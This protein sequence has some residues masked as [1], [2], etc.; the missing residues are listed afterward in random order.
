MSKN[1]IV[2]RTIKPLMKKENTSVIFKPVVEY[3]RF[4]DHNY[5]FYY[6]HNDEVKVTMTESFQSKNNSEF[7][8]GDFDEAVPESERI[9][10]LMAAASGLTTGAI[11]AVY[12]K[13]VS[14]LS[15]KIKIDSKE[16]EKIIVLCA[17][18]AGYSKKDYKGAVN[19]ILSSAVSRT[20]LSEHPSLLGLICSLITQN[21]EVTYSFDE[22]G[23]L[24]DKKVPDYYKIG[25]DTEEKIIYGL[26]YWIFNMA[27]QYA[28]SK[29]DYFEELGL[30]KELVTVL[31][32]FAA[33]ELIKNMPKGIENPEKAFSEFLQKAF[34]ESTVEEDEGNSVP[35]KFA[36]VIKA[37]LENV[38][39]DFSLTLL[40]EALFRSFYCVRRLLV[41]A[42]ANNI[43]NLDDLLKLDRKE[44]LP[45]D[46]RI[47]SRM[48]VIAHG[49]YAA[50]NIAGAVT[51]V[52]RNKQKNTAD[53]AKVLLAE[54]GI[55][56]I[57]RFVY[58]VAKDSKYW[59]E[60]V[61]V[62]MQR[63][64]KSKKK[65]TETETKDERI[66]DE[67]QRNKA[68]GV[69]TLDM[70]Q[71]RLLYSLEAISVKY[72]IQNTKKEE[73]VLTKANWLEEWKNNILYGFGIN[74]MS[75]FV[76]DEGIIYDSIYELSKDKTNWSWMY[77]VATELAL[78]KPYHPLNSKNDGEYGKLKPVY[79]YVKNQF[80]R[81]Q[82]V[83]IQSEMEDIVKTYEKNKGIISGQTQNTIV[84]IG[85]ATVAVVTTGGAAFAFAPQ[86]AVLLAGEAVAGLHGAALT[87]ASLAFIG[88][89]SI[90]AG[91]LGMAGGTAII[92][93]GGA[94]LGMA[95]TGG[96]SAAN[97]ILHTP[98][99]HLLKQSAKLL[100]FSEC[101]I[102]NKLND[103]DA[104]KG[105]LAQLDI[106]IGELS[107]EIVELENENNDLDKAYIKKSKTYLKY[108][109]K[110][111]SELEKKCKKIK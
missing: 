5:K 95:G 80:I 76:E 9:Y 89:G 106:M 82:T 111:S 65:E 33:S 35:F 67:E 11:G 91:G 6:S 42:K 10:Y 31:K 71:T 47:I 85:A 36:E 21:T 64:K 24:K 77:L 34:E 1:E 88:G 87:S 52:L 86:I 17:S 56:G 75:Y 44:F 70:L 60:D 100:A 83:V 20:Q 29:R 58:A 63:V 16:L 40:N 94:L 57:G 105:I 49:T 66:F 2:L 28:D 55:V 37:T 78:F 27:I 38:D 48:A 101:V 26:F 53:F 59:A 3:Q 14:I 110:S 45:I 18:I 79:D 73:D 61:D 4:D 108:L 23:K 32:E 92:T 54:V 96:I 109:Q 74:D 62:L 84:G 97:M 90:A 39:I 102:I 98:V 13:I 41:C 22:K 15:G 69:L 72:D 81:R 103:I 51:Q 12:P 7:V 25:R 46:N 50:I 43:D 68:F 99:E 93:G 8:A 30:P 107:G 104:I 19:F